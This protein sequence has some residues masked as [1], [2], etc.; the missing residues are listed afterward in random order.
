MSQWEK[1]ENNIH[2]PDGTSL[3]RKAGNGPPCFIARVTE[4]ASRTD[5]INCACFSLQFGFPP[6]FD[7]SF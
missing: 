1:E 3:G 2:L 5:R 6:Y 7:Y 4:R